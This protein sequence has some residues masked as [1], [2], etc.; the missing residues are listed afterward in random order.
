MKK[1]LA[2]LSSLLLAWACSDVN[3]FG[4][5]D[6][7]D[8]NV[9]VPQKVTIKD[10]RNTNGGAVIKVSIPDDNNLKGVVAT[11]DRNGTTVNAKISRYV[12]SLVVEGF[13][14][15]DSHV[16]EVASF[17]INEVKSEPVK[18]TINP[19]PSAIQTASP[20]ITEAFG[21]I[22]I[23]VTG[24]ESKSDLAV[25]ILRCEDVSQADKSV[26]DIK[27][28]EVTTLFTAS[29]NITLTRRNLEPVKAI[30]GV[31]FRDHWGNKSDTSKVVLTPLEETKFPLDKYAYY[32]PGDDNSSSTNST[33]YPIKGLWDGSGASSTGHFYA[34]NSTDPIP[35]WLTIDLGVR[36]KI[37]RITTLPRIAYVIYSG[38]HP[39]EF[40]F[41]GSMGPTGEFVEGN[42]YGFDN[43]W[44]KLGR[45]SQGKPSGYDADGTVGTI[46]TEDAEY[47]NAGND[48]ELDPSE[49]PDAYNDVRYL[50]VV[51][52]NTFS[53]YELHSTVGQVQ[54]GE[55]N[56]WGQILEKYR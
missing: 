16:V 31:Y 46:T 8:E 38:A 33:Y 28:V 41:W 53:T 10:V 45:F 20:T 26:K 54:F 18:V 34:S 22:K 55:V 50:R 21:G 47:F 6:Q 14:D 11:Y 56:A 43:T 29:N 4:R 32:N 30:Y 23:H 13:S 49:Y 35:Q 51:F 25:C 17:N 48:F 52:L 9:P 1:T 3:E 37:S 5:V 44:F 40:E 36:G 42:E 15:T 27:W 39:R 12:D 7:L 19:L 2:I 24:N